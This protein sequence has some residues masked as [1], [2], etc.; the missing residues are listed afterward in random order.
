MG[1]GI[2]QVGVRGIKRSLRLGEIQVEVIGSLHPPLF[3]YALTRSL[4]LSTIEVES[5]ILTDFASLL[6]GNSTAAM[7]N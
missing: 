4:P 2:P 3:K 1:R 7:A 6:G 5:A